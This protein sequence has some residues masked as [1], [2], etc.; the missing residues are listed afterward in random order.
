MTRNSVWLSLLVAATILFSSALPSPVSAQMVSFI[1][2]KDF[3]SGSSP[4]SV[5][6]GDFN[7]D[8]KPDLAVANAFDPGSVSVLLG[9]GD[10]TFQAP[11]SFATGSDPA[12]VVLGDFNGDGKADLLWRNTSGGADNGKIVIWEMNGTQRLVDTTIAK[13]GDEWHFQATG[14]YNGDAKSDIVWRNDAG[15]TVLWEM[16]GGQKLADVNLPSIPTDWTLVH[17]QFDIV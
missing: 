9:N 11:V 6:V 2:H 12:A 13:L 1:A 16:N 7:G 4:V 8:G 5:A 17:H 10:G 15:T 3:V 14:D